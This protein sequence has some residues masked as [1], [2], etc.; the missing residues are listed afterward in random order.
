[1]RLG[2]SNPT[3]KL[4]LLA[5]AVAL[6]ATTAAAAKTYRR[7]AMVTV[8]G[9]VSDP[10]E[11]GRIEGLRIDLLVSKK[12]GGPEGK[13]LVRVSTLSD[14][15]GRFSFDWKWNPYYNF[16]RVHVVEVSEQP[17]GA[18]V[19][20]LLG[21]VDLSRR[22]LEGSPVVVAVGLEGPSKASSKAVPKAS[23]EVSSESPAVTPTRPAAAPE[24]TTDDAVSDSGDPGPSMTVS[25]EDQRGIYDQMGK[26]DR[27][28]RLQLS[29]A[30]EVT[31]WYFSDGVSYYFRDGQL[32][33]TVEFEAIPEP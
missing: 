12:G 30:E 16:F 3:V 23:S 11:E 1:M 2:S 4:L 24:P 27:V 10:F 8:T 25:G 20:R 26:P 29:S 6:S 19:E 13:G 5:A 17:N 32:Y 28:D 7:G 14:E 9:S 31:W 22:I 33:Q 18:S 15:N 21:E